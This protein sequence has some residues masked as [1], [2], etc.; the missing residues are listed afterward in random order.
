[1]SCVFVVNKRDDVK[2]LLGGSVWCLLPRL[3]CMP[4]SSQT[5]VL[6]SVV[7]TCLT[8]NEIVDTPIALKPVRLRSNKVDFISQ[9]YH[10]GQSTEGKALYLAYVSFPETFT[11]EFIVL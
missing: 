11:K 3:V 6:L 9:N 10:N 1:M 7:F 5:A 4:S 2:R 8:V